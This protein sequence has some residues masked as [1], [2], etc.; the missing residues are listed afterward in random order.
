[1]KIVYCLIDSSQAG[2]MERSICT[3][4]NYLADVA[5]YE[6]T[7]ITT[8]RRKKKNFYDFSPNIRFVDLGVNYDELA[9]LPF[10]EK[11]R[12]QMQKRKL[13]RQRLS[14]VLFDLK[15]DI[16]ISTYT[17]ELTILC[18]IKDGSKKI[19]EHH[20]SKNYIAI[21]YAQ[22]SKFSLKRIFAICAEK[23]K[24]RFVCRYD[25]FVVLTHGDRRLWKKIENIHVIPNILPF[26]PGRFSSGDHKRAISAGRLS[27]EKGFPFLL[28]AWSIVVRKYIDWRLDIY[29]N[30]EEYAKLDA[31]IQSLRLKDVVTI[32][33][34]VK[35]IE[36]EYRNSS[37]YVMSS[38]YEGFSMAFIEAMACGLPCVSFDT[39]TGPAEVIT[40]GEDGIVVEH[41]NVDKLAEAIMFLIED[42][43]LR[44][45]MGNNARENIKRFLPEYIM[46]RW[47][48]LFEQLTGTSGY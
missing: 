28:K 26:Y 18:K 8:D 29:G 45:S 17:H 15:P 33:R 9:G 24:Q 19:V 46:P 35:D 23:R 4:A 37:L 34:P 30:G 21:S 1:M 27:Y 39:P 41:K 38:L 25:A 12:K 11:I 36:E 48:A 47:I 6:V 44:K 43:A 20:F 42:E 5:G 32:H 13:H 7:I 40:Q 2:G 22:K 31:M 16:S 10:V 3:K 14:E